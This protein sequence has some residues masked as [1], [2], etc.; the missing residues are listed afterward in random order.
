MMKDEGLVSLHSLL[1]TASLI[2]TG[3][4]LAGMLNG[5]SVGPLLRR[6]DTQCLKMC[7]TSRTEVWKKRAKMFKN[8]NEMQRQIFLYYNFSLLCR[9][10]KEQ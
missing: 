6:R 8:Q 1:S 7:S 4:R 3:Q 9:R 2:K 10:L 5:N